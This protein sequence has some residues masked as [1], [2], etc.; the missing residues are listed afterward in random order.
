MKTSHLLASALLL[1]TAACKGA[2]GA[3]SLDTVSDLSPQPPMWVVSDADSEITLYPTIHILPKDITWKSDTMRERLAA[4]DEVWF[5]IQPGSEADPKLQQYVMSKAM[6]P[7]SPLSSKL[8]PELYAKLEAQTAALG[9]PVEAVDPM[10]PWMAGMT[11]GVMALVKEGFDP[12]SGVETQLTPMVAGKK[13]R[14]LETSQSQIDMLAG[15]PD[16]VQIEFLRSAIEDMEEGAEMLNEMAR[17]WSVGDIDDM[18]E[19]LIEET[20]AEAPELFEAMFVNRNRNWAKQIAAEMEGSG[21]DFIAVGAGHLVGDDSVP[22]MLLD[23]G[24][25]VE[26][27]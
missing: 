2:P 4:A 6:T 26:R 27:L 3:Q 15:L 24:Y 20:K 8:T 9:I 1:F 18:E 16:A 25:K 19:D 11:L 13:V 23:M 7:D 10:A 21:T 22:Q 17:D 12:G 14:A 5:E